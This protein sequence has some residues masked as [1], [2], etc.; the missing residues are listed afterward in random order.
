MVEKKN[1]DPGIEHTDDHRPWT[2]IVEEVASAVPDRLLAY[3]RRVSDDAEL[4]YAV[5]PARIT[6][7]NSG[8]LIFGF[9]LLSPPDNLAGPLVLRLNISGERTLV[10]RRELALQ[11]AA[12]RLGCKV[13]KVR[14]TESGGKDMGG[15]FFIMDRVAGGS[16]AKWW[17]TLILIGLFASLVLWHGWPLLVGFFLGSLLVG[18]TLTQQQRKLHRINLEDVRHIY[19]QYCLE[20]A[21][22]DVNLGLRTIVDSASDNFLEE[23][24]TGWRW[25]QTHRPA[26][27]RPRLCHGDFHALNILGDWRQV[28][29]IV[30]WEAAC[31]ADPEYDAAIS[32][33]L[34]LLFGWIGMLMFPTYWIHRAFLR[35]KLDRERFLYYQARLSWL[36][37][38]LWAPSLVERMINGTSWLDK[39]LT[40]IAIKNHTRHFRKIT[41]VDLPTI[42]ELLK[43]RT[44]E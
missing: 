28:T 14:L 21:D 11:D 17:I 38:I 8:A 23:F 18:F 43:K 12:G 25:L 42:A 9:E 27:A 22:M 30:D 26:T 31:I 3:L 40:R 19:N 44:T 34:P 5:P 32:R 6:A 36:I 15:P 10:Q 33:C 41:G 37:V 35:G 29:S 7:G 24:G 13:P 39:T 4:Q 20:D 2:E 1:Q 16:I